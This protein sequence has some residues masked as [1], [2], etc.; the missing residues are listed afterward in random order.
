MF[1]WRI[2]VVIDHQHP[3]APETKL[4]RRVSIYWPGTMIRPNGAAVARVS[5]IQEAR[6]DMR[7]LADTVPNYSSK[8]SLPLEL[9][10]RQSRSHG[11]ASQHTAEHG[12]KTWTDAMAR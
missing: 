4:Q 3:A 7:L 10:V 9:R 1:S 6:G 12:T 2:H 5:K 11:D 8:N